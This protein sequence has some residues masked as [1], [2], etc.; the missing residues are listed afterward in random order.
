MISAR[1]RNGP[2]LPDT[3]G[4]SGTVTQV[5]RFPRA[6]IGADGLPV[7]LYEDLTSG[8]LKIARCGTSDC[9]D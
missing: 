8:K 7:I 5:S 4:G 6:Q 1:F 3:V 9:R 2:L